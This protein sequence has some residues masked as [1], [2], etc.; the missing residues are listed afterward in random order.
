MYKRRTKETERIVINGKP[1]FGL[2][3]PPPE[4]VD[5][6]GVVGPFGGFRVPT[7]LT[8]L[9][10]KSRLQAVFMTEEGIALVDIFDDKAFG[11]FELV[12]GD[13]REGRTAKS[14]HKF[15]T[16]RRRFVPNNTLN[17]HCITLGGK[18]NCKVSWRT[19]RNG[20]KSFLLDIDIPRERGALGR[21][22]VTGMM[23]GIIE[24]EVCT[25]NKAPNK[26]RPSATWIAM[27]NGYWMRE[28]CE[29]D[30]LACM[31]INRAYYPMRSKVCMVCALGKCR[32][33]TVML[34][35]WAS[36]ME[37]ADD[38]D[39][40]DSSENVLVCDGEITPI[41][42]VAVTRVG[43]DAKSVNNRN[44]QDTRGMVDLS[45]VGNKEGNSRGA[46]N[47]LFIRTEWET[48]FGTLEG[49]LLTKAGE[50]LEVHLPCVV[51]SS[52]MRI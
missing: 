28:G 1:Q 29:T 22:G 27:I 20:Q 11:L 45:F 14:Y 40:S 6:K 10:I 17:G 4:K 30:A 38:E 48:M 47:L 34:H 52:S 9:R 33:H 3:A 39:E 41:A 50:K 23:A 18:R 24:R 36:S 31:T 7:V 26:R 2:F 21:P 25:V 16:M 8:N 43:S 13:S 19:K 12:T 32:E 37:A 51:R 46:L 42:P 49:T 15:M 35:L 44:I 5:I